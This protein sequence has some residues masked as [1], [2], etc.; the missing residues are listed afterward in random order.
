VSESLKSVH[1]RLSLRKLET[2]PTTKK[3]ATTTTDDKV[4][5]DADPIVKKKVL[6]LRERF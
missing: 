6:T 1:R 3:P 5:T 4:K 2:K